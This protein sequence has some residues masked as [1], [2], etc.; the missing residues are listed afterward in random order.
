NELPFIAVLPDDAPKV[1]L[2]WQRD[3]QLQLDPPEGT[4]EKHDAI[5]KY[6]C[7]RADAAAVVV[8]MAAEL[9]AQPKT[10]GELATL[11]RLL[12]EGEV[13]FDVRTGRM[14]SAALKVEREIKG[15][16]GE[17][18]SYKVVSTYTEQIVP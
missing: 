13:V 9:K 8:K 7:T 18:S 16:Q 14:H 15:Q 10:Q 5:H 4:G 3:Y 6:T 17:G 1:G 12:P 11:L 2:A